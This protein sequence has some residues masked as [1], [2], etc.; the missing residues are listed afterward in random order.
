M[1]H[2]RIINISDLIKDKEAKQK[3]L[4]YYE[5]CLEDLLR[6]MSMVKNQIDLTE[7]IINMIKTESDDLLEKYFEKK[8]DS[9]L[10]N[11]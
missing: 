11:I 9:R 4:E 3:E 6:K 2:D 1:S 10:L 7:I 5:S 8:D